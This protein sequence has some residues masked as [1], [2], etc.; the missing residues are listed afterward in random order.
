M[1]D[2]MK[3]YVFII[4]SKGIPAG[5]GGFE[6]FVE[7]LTLNQ[8]DKSIQYYVSCQ[9]SPNGYNPDLFEHNGAVC[10]PIKVPD[11]G[12]GRAVY[13]DWQSLRWSMDFIKKNK[14]KNAIIFICGYRIGPFISFYKKRMKRLGIKLIINPDGH[15]WLRAKWN[16]AIKKY[17]RISEKLSMKY[18][19]YV[20]CDSMNI[21]SYVKED[22]RQYNPKTTFVAYGAETSK[23]HLEDDD[24][25]IVDWY[26]KWELVPGEYYLNVAR[27]VPE[28]NY[29]TIIREF[30]AS[31]TPKS[32]VIVS[33]F[34]KVKF[35]ERLKEK[36]HFDNDERIKFVDAIYDQELLKKI[37]E[38]A[39]GYIHGHS[40]GGS[41]PSLL[42]ALGT[43][44]L[45]LI[46]D[47]CFNNEVAENSALYWTLEQG[48]LKELIEKS[49]AMAPGEILDLGRL[50]HERI[51]KYYTW[52]YI[53][54]RYEHEFNRGF[55]G[56]Y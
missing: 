13:Y 35:Y 25:Q 26:R 43:I 32:L 50:A 48:S 2:E 15:E 38:N 7:K 49:D 16:A 21:E 23:S 29:E 19:D 9:K 10:F 20:I 40:V 30:M 1:A 47:C 39:Y 12:A 28:N 54:K 3:K 53:V 6:T 4:G 41:N 31:N 44:N 55:A 18:T 27:L 8:T 45:N 56:E 14:I 46:Y 52:E 37:R 42:E 22:F 24:S 11:V 17:W 51:E 33:S 36:T 34:D 5:Y